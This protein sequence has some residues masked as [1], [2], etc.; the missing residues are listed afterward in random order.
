MLK[1]KDGKEIKPDTFI[2][3]VPAFRLVEHDNGIDEEYIFIRVAIADQKVFFIM[4][5]NNGQYSS[6]PM[7]TNATFS[8]Q[9]GSPYTA[10]ECEVDNI[11]IEYH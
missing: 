5:S 9:W 7:P 4:I 3:S 6:Y 11:D 10:Y 2:Y 1:R 8:T